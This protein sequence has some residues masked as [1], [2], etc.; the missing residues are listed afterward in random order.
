MAYVDVRL[1]NGDRSVGS[2]FHIGEGVFVTARH[3]VEHNT[4]VEVKITEPLGITAQE[5]L[6]SILDREPTEDEIKKENQIYSRN[7]EIPLFRHYHEPLRIS[8]GPHFSSAA[9]LDVAVFRVCNLHPAAGVVRLGIHWDDWIYRVQWQMS[10]AVVLGYPPIPMVNTPLLVAARAEIHTYVQPRYT[11]F[12]H[13]ILSAIPRG[14]FSGG[15]AIHESG[16]ALGLITSSFV[17]DGKPPE[18]G[19]FAVLSVEGI[20][21]CLTENSLYTETQRQHHESRLGFDPGPVLTGI[22]SSGGDTGPQTS[23]RDQS[24]SEDVPVAA[25]PA[26]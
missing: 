3:V 5:Y 1:P 23:T 13:F 18:L 12:L 19:F 2:A 16:D 15:V 6:K 26:E 20:V 24:I 25:K 8:E 14:G 7:G 4:I 17:A 10:E 11:H 22:R 21:N 9:E